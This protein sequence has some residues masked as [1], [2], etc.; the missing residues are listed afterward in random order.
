MR[1]ASDCR[2]AWWL[3]AG[4]IVVACIMLLPVLGAIAYSH[5]NLGQR[6][7]WELGVGLVAWNETILLGFLNFSA[8]IGL[9]LLT[10]SALA[11]LYRVRPQPRKCGGT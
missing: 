2:R 7:W 3:A 8:G 4:R 10:R 6:S 9:A 1:I 11:A 5:A